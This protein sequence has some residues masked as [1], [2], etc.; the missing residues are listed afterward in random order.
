MNLN[1]AFKLSLNSAFLEADNHSARIW[2]LMNLNDCMHVAGIGRE[3]YKQMSQI[4]F[5]ILWFL[6]SCLWCLW[7]WRNSWEKF[8]AA[9]LLSGGT[10]GRTCPAYKRRSSQQKA[11]NGAKKVHGAAAT[12]LSPNKS[13]CTAVRW[14]LTTIC[15]LGSWAKLADSLFWLGI[16]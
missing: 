16:Q 9:S 15:W 8:V 12:K 14:L 4:W 3:I 1:D 7:L 2:W 5:T 13:G 11:K 10:R 6:W